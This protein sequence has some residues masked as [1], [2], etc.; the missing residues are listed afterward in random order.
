V[1]D[2]MAGVRFLGRGL[3]MYG[4]TPGLVVLGVIPAVISAILFVAAF[5][6]LVVFVDEL[7][8]AVTWFA[9]DWSPG[10]R[11]GVR[12]L[13]GTGIVGG[14]LVLG[15]VTYTAVTLL[16]GDPFYER[17]SQRIE[18]RFGGVPGAVEVR[19]WR[20]LLDSARLILLSVSV[21]IPLFLAGFI[22]LVGQTLIPVIA[23]A[24]GGWF[25]AVELVGVPFSRRGLRLP[26]RR[27]VLRSRRAM[28]LG[29]GMSVFLCCLV[30]FVAVLVMP[31]AVAGGTLLAREVLGLSTGET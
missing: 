17:I 1:K 18:D 24:A 15:I 21:T 10:P 5:V 11:N 16:I 31:G 30:P 20:S 8:G 4:R 27:R 12:I 2:F 6:V 25:L 23:A 29:F 14:A 7:A 28:A 3:A 9:D 13:A 26:D 22:P 19:W